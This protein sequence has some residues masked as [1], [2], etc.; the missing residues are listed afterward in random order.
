MVS[1]GIDGLFDRS[2][3]GVVIYNPFVLLNPEMVEKF[4]G[5]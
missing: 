3:D 4:T 5:G 1:N 2:F